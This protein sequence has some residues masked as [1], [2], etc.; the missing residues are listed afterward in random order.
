MTSTKTF[1]EEE[2]AGWDAKAATYGGYA[3]RVTVQ[4]AP[5]VLDAAGVGA[6]TALLDI[7]SG[8]GY[9]AAAGAARG[10]RVIGVDFAPSMVAEARRLH[11]A[12][13]F[14][15]GD[16]EALDF[17]AG[18]FDAVTC[19]FG[20][21]HFA[22]PDKAIAEALRVLRSGGRYAFTWWCAN[23]RH[24]FNRHVLGTI[25]TLGD[26]NVPMPEAPPFARFS[27]PAE[28]RRSLE[29]AGFGDVRVGERALVY[30]ITSPRDVLDF[31]SKSAV[32]TAMLLE[33]QAPETRPRIEKALL[34]GAE[35]FRQGDVYRF[36]APA[37]V[38][39]GRKP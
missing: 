30:E 39:S 25:A 27:E 36:A 24:E 31:I 5:H 34:E 9:V 20:I 15:P 8:P 14:R 33:R 17:P 1:R 2:L 13:D 37:L 21:G 16:A 12:I 4:V 3:G 32:R 35:R 19:A 7:A 22:Q 10:A 23:D 11:P 38:A 28:C 26:L 6:S 18:A 29:A